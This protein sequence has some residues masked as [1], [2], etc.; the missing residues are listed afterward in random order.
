[1][2]LR[3]V[4]YFAIVAEHGNV[5][6]ASEALELSPT[7]VSKSLR[8][9]EASMGAKLVKRT[10][11]GVDLTAVGSALLARVHRLRLTLE[12]VQREAG[13]LSQGRMGHIRL[14]V[15]PHATEA[16]RAAYVALQKDAPELTMEILVSDR[17]VM[18]PMLRNGT[19]DLVV[20]HLGP[21]EVS[22][23][24]EFLG[25]SEYVIFASTSHPLTRKKRVTVAELSRERWALNSPQLSSRAWFHQVFD[26]KGLPRPRVALETRHHQLR[27]SIVASSRLLGF[28]S[29]RSVREAARAY[30]LAEVR[31]DGFPWLRRDGVIY[32]KDA[33]LSPA[34]K[35]FIEIL[36]AVAKESA[37][38]K[39]RR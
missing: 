7:A 8:R 20:N 22:I 35:R 33:Y 10:A 36:K 3:D 30:P 4:E 34:A 15:G 38:E 37:P 32:R 1:M 19:L 16:A 24:Q 9:L 13:D 26:A 6:R 21:S 23:E 25:E 11:R 27:F 17:D 18:H 39:V 28:T 14:G 31:A 5:R 2:E 29:R 12:D